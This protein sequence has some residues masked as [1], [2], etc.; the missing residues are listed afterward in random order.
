MH[1]QNLLWKT[2][3]LYCRVGWDWLLKFCAQICKGKEIPMWK[4]RIVH[5]PSLPWPSAAS[6][7]N[8]GCECCCLS[9]AQHPSWFPQAEAMSEEVRTSLL[10]WHAAFLSESGFILFPHR[11]QMVL[12]A[13]PPVAGHGRGGGEALIASV[14]AGT[15][16]AAG[17]DLQRLI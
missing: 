8:S 15:S 11:I 16:S 14:V 5:D 2:S 17:V 1:I 13:A 7:H 3:L 9:W 4:C 12:Y 6:I 10:H